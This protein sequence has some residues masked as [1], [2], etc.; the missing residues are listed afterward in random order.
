MIAWLAAV[1][2]CTNHTHMCCN[3]LAVLTDRVEGPSL[4]NLISEYDSTEE[5]LEFTLSRQVT[6]CISMR[7]CQNPALG[8]V[9]PQHEHHHARQYRRSEGDPPHFGIS[10]KEV[11]EITAE[12]RAEGAA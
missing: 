9:L 12:E 10:C 4:L 1:L 6:D 11:E 5:I 7:R 3:V 8:P 2:M